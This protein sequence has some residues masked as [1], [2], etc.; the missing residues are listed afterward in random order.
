VPRY[1]GVVAS[2]ARR[3]RPAAPY[4]PPKRLAA[5][6]L[7]GLPSA[8]ALRLVDAVGSGGFSLLFV[9]YGPVAEP[10][11]FRISSV[12]GHGASP[13]VGRNVYSTG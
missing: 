10:L 12:R 2:G 5:L 6:G 1:K 9:V 11:A 4:L 8:A 7:P 3:T 13:A